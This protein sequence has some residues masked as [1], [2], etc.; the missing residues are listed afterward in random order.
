[1]NKKRIKRIYR[2]S[3]VNMLTALAVL[4]LAAIE[5]QPELSSEDTTITPESLAE[6]QARI[7]LITQKHLGKDVARLTRSATDVVLDIFEEAYP[8][9]ISAKSFIERKSRR[10]PEKGLELTTKL[11]LSTYMEDVQN[12]DQE[13]FV[14]MLFQFRENSTEDVK[15]ALLELGFPQPK[16]DIIFSFADSLNKANITQESLK[17]SQLQLTDEAI[18]DFNELY[19]DVTDVAGAGKQ[20]FR[21]Q[22]QIAERFNYTGIIRTMNNKRSTNNDETPAS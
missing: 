12:G 16:L 21:D 17:K 15:T 22:P 1:M 19:L 13:A 4:M 7:N 18:S 14:A 2:G 8:Y 10:N 3:D 9:V 11:G 5:Y 20:Y 6:L